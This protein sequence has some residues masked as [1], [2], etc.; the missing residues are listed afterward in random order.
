M[1]R[2]RPVLPDVGST[3]SS[4]VSSPCSRAC[5]IM[6]DAMRSLT[7]PNGLYHSSLANTSVCT[8][9]TTWLSLTIGVGF[10]AFESSP[11]IES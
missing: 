9:G 11:S 7:E 8:N 6:L 4:S 10:S 2:P 5:W 1:I 3:R